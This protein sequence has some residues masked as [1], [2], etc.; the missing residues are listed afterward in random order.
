MNDENHK[1]IALRDP[2]ILTIPV[3]A[4]AVALSLDW[5]DG[6]N[7]VRSRARS[8]VLAEAV[9]RS[10]SESRSFEVKLR[11]RLHELFT[12]PQPEEPMPDS[13]M[14]VI[15]TPT[16]PLVCCWQ[17][18]AQ[19][20]EANDKHHDQGLTPVELLDRSP[21]TAMQHGVDGQLQ[22]LWEI[23]DL[24]SDNQKLARLTVV[25]HNPRAREWVPLDWAITQNNIGTALATLSGLPGTS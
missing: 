13:R 18:I 11:A 6:R 15:F 8:L 21:K 24:S 20:D 19:S 10:K 3:C 12:P 5:L 4:F 17:S 7:R 2:L 25:K 14:S 22:I 1:N 9:Q 16:G 23:S